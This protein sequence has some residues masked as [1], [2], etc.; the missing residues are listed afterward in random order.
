M[1]STGSFKYVISQSNLYTSL[2][3]IAHTH[4]SIHV[5]RAWFYTIALLGL[6]VFAIIALPGCSSPKRPDSAITLFARNVESCICNYLDIEDDNPSGLTYK[7]FV[8]DC[9]ETVRESHPNRFTKLEDSEPTMD[10]LRC[11][12]KVESWLKV[13]A[14]QA[15]LREN[16]RRLMQEL[17]EYLPVDNTDSKVTE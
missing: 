12:E 11:P 1:S 4:A 9:N 8:E 2:R 15:Q 14:E 16:N 10:S 6:L 3:K 7:D 17:L 5:A 13:I